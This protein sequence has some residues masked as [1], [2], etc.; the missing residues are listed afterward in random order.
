MGL[1]GNEADHVL[2]RVMAGAPARRARAFSSGIRARL[3]ISHASRAF[4]LSLWPGLGRFLASHG[5]DCDIRPEM[6]GEGDSS[7][8]KC[9]Q[10]L[11]SLVD[12]A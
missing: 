11:G 7:G 12:V 8:L 10:R 5:V 4:S 3:T 6:E 1:D 9:V 2:G